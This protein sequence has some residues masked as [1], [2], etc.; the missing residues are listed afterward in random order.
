VWE[1]V[2]AS[3]HPD[4][5]GVRELLDYAADEVIPLSGTGAGEVDASVLLAVTSFDGQ[6]CVLIGQDRRRSITPAGLR[7]ARR[8]MRLAQELRLPLVA[9]VDTAGADLSPQAE[10]GALS[11]EIAR[12]VADFVSLTVPSV[13][14]LLGE[15][16]GGAALALLAARHV[17]A[18][19]HAWLAPLPP[20]GAA[21]LAYRDVGRAPD[22]AERQRIGAWDLLA[23]GIVRH[24][25]AEPVPAHLDPI[26]FVRTVARVCAHFIG[27]QA[28]E[29]VPI[30]T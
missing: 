18:A 26:G 6:P 2:V 3:R 15:G 17:I 13:S 25:V 20:E 28:T 9:V 14:I 21:A 30:E 8:G 19:E 5:P 10:E 27:E 4:R 24:V 16:A 11:G 23:R 7:G 29:P 22:M 12:C 1:S